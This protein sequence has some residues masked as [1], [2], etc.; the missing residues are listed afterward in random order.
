MLDGMCGL[1]EAK[2]WLKGTVKGAL[3][4][5]P[6][7]CESELEVTVGIGTVGDVVALPFSGAAISGTVSGT[8]DVVGTGA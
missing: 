4:L 5:P 1:N 7:E 8:V 6:C 3:L 2:C